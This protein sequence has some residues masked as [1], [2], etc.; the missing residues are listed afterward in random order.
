MD[1]DKFQ[2]LVL[3]QLAKLT[4]GQDKVLKDIARLED[5]QKEMRQ[6]IARLED[7]QDKIHQDMARLEFSH[8]EKLAALFDAYQSISEILDDHT[9]RLERIEEKVSMHEIQIKVL[10][11]TKS[12]KRKA[13]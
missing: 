5:G 6:D 9:R 1:N 10:D 2:E 13:K 12:N 4:G 11:A 3:E 8:G 7:G